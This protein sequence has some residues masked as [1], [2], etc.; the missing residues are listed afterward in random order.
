[1]RECDTRKDT[2]E[3]LPGQRFFDTMLAED[4]VRDLRFATEGPGDLVKS[5]KDRFFF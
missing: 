2:D 1:L 5:I 3:Q 4:E